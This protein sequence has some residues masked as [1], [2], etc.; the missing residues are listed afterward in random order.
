MGQSSILKEIN[1]KVTGMTELMGDGGYIGQMLQSLKK[2]IENLPSQIANDKNSSRMALQI[3]EVAQKIDTLAGNEGMN[4][5]E[6]MQI[7]VQE[8]LE[9]AP[10]IRE[11]RQKAD[12]IQGGIEI[13]QEKIEKELIGEDAP[14]IKVVYS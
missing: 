8:G 7:S 1:E 12:R 14:I 5:S 10:S 6:L 13:V 11:I 4:L 9:Q 2:D 3:N